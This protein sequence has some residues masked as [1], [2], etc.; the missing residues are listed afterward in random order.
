MSQPPVGPIIDGDHHHHHKQDHDGLHFSIPKP[1]LRGRGR[2]LHWTGKYWVNEI[3]AGRPNPSLQ[4]TTSNQST[5]VHDRFQLG[6]LSLVQAIPDWGPYLDGVR[7]GERQIHVTGT[8][9]G[10]ALSLFMGLWLF[11]VRL[12]P[13]VLR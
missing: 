13:H 7:Q 11:H 9:L 2:P 6:F 4:S 10:G 12:F 8:S 3:G 5:Q 1:F